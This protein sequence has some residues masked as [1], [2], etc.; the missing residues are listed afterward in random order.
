[1]IQ[2]LWGALFQFLPMPI[3]SA[4]FSHLFSIP[5]Q[6]LIGLWQSTAM[7]LY[8]LIW[9]WIVIGR[10]GRFSLLERITAG[11]WLG[12]VSLAFGFVV[13]GTAQ[14]LTPVAGWTWV[15]AHLAI[16]LLIPKREYELP[17]PGKLEGKTERTLISLSWFAI[18]L[19]SLLTFYHA[20][21]YPPVYWDALLYYLQHPQ[22][23]VE[24]GGFPTV[25][26]SQ[27]GMGLAANYPPLYRA[28]TAGIPSLFGGWNP[29]VGQF[30]PPLGGLLATLLIYAWL[31]RHFKNRVLAVAGALCFRSLP[32]ATNY[33]IL[34]CNYSMTVAAVAAFLW[35]AEVVM[36]KKDT[37]LFWLALLL[38]AFAC[39]LNYLMLAIIFPAA[40]LVIIIK[41][42]LP[43]VRLKATA[44]FGAL[45][46]FIAGFWYMRNWCITGNPVYPFFHSIL[47]GNNIQ[48]HIMEY[49]KSEWTSN[50]DGLAGY[51][52]IANRLANLHNYLFLNQPN[53][54]WKIQP[55]LLAYIIPGFIVSIFRPK[56][57]MII[58][59]S[60][61]V[62]LAGYG[63]S[64]G[65]YYLYHL[66]P[67]APVLAMLAARLLATMD[68]T[69]MRNA[70][71]AWLLL[72]ALGPGLTIAIMGSK[73]PYGDMW[74]FRHPNP[75]SQRLFKEVPSIGSSG[76]MWDYINRECPNSVILTHENRSYYLSQSVT[77]L[78]LDDPKLWPL[79]KQQDPKRVFEEFS[80][81]GITH[82]L[83]IP[84]QKNYH[85]TNLLSL[86]RV[87][88]G[89]FN[90]Y[91]EPI[92]INP[93]REALFKLKSVR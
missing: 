92:K 9:G 2:H 3:S 25:V 52:S 76:R 57:E 69:H 13:L 10:L 60:L 28:L 34:A 83:Y 14:L 42:E 59:G 40:A 49:M 65:G 58:W 47:G 53:I 90:E 1:M 17:E 37:R 43:P 21:L 23:S 16:L 15:V 71:L 70:A 86:D 88:R 41:K 18:G 73:A 48:P 77:L 31:L 81:L 36:Q 27:V 89:E 29:G 80:R 72:L 64:G 8:C 87:A 20:L 74:A 91:F 33:S 11:C 46:L 24:Q 79:Y 7:T 56:K 68:N 84:N 5:A 85:V 63:L 54:M 82:Y 44:G 67:L 78:N 39:N 30:L 66:L 26:A 35:L 50:G 12:I 61:L 22:I 38:A 45:L 6:T 55:W 75:E 32:L 51:G 62:V 4:W 93:G 19:I